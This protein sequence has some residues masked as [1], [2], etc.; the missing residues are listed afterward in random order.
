MDF[1]TLR[2]LSLPILSVRQP[3]ASYISSGMKSVELRSWAP[4]YKGWLWIHTGKKP[5]IVALRLLH[6][7][8][9][10]FDFGGLVGLAKV[11]HYE[12]IDSEKKWLSLKRD[13]LSPGWFQ[14]NCYGWHFND[15]LSLPA[16]IECPGELGLFH[17]TGAVRDFV[18]KQIN[19]DLFHDFVEA[20]SAVVADQ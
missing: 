17:L 7:D 5:D 11:D 9:K 10:G 1:I 15:A 20:A 16:L 2:L 18:Y 14:G 13:H 8:I 3:W 6:L 12:F 4:Q 19:Q